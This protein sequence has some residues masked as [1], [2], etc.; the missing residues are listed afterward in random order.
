MIYFDKIEVVNRLAKSH[1]WNTVKTYGVDYDRTWI[2]DKIHHEI[3]QF[4]SSH[5]LQEVYIEQFDILDESLTEALQSDCDKYDVGLEIIA[6]RVTKPRVPQKIRD[7]YEKMEEKITL[8]KVAEE[9]AHVLEREEHI[10]ATRARIVAER[11]KEVAQIE[12]EQ[13]AEVARIKADRELAVSQIQTL[14]QIAEKEAASK[15][16]DID[17]AINTKRQKAMSDARNYATEAEARGLALKLTPPF[18]QYTL[19]SSVGSSPKTFY[20][21]DILEIFE[22]WLGSTTDL[23]VAGDHQNAPQP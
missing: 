15:I 14:Q 9:E 1:A 2:F 8:L 11:E 5:S 16:A 3:N 17:N 4:C 22:P 6:A 18:L 7:N 23:H 13:Q 21:R 10:K 12:A 20:G 19:F